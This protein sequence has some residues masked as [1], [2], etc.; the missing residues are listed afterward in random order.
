[1]ELQPGWL[2]D[3]DVSMRHV[4]HIYFP[5]HIG[6]LVIPRSKPQRRYADSYWELK[7]DLVKMRLHFKP[8]TIGKHMF[9]DHNGRICLIALMPKAFMEV[10]HL[11]VDCRVRINGTM[12]LYLDELKPI[13]KT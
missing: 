3:V 7:L 5:K 1:M 13:T 2:D 4:L 10:T 12:M 9:R 8:S 11:P 6:K